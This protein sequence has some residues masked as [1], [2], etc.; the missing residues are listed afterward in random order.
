MEAIKDNA[1]AIYGYGPIPEEVWVYA[2]SFHPTLWKNPPR[3]AAH[4][5]TQEFLK[6]LVP[7]I[8]ALGVYLDEI[9]AAT[10]LDVVKFNPKLLRELP[11]I[12]YK[13]PD[14]LRCAVS[15]DGRML[16]WGAH[17]VRDNK[18]VVL[19][20]VK[21]EGY[22]LKYASHGLKSDREVCLAAVRNE[23]YFPEEPMRWGSF[24]VH[25]QVL[26]LCSL[27][28]QEDKQVV[29]AFLAQ[30]AH[31]MYDDFVFELDSRCNLSAYV[32]QL[33]E[34][35]DNF[36]LFNLGQNEV[37]ERWSAARRATGNLRLPCEN[38]FGQGAA[39]AARFNERILEFLLPCRQ[40]FDEAMA[41]RDK[42]N[43]VRVNRLEKAAL[44]ARADQHRFWEKEKARLY[45]KR[46]RLE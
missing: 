35:Y 37:K 42:L 24:S 33:D 31:T 13:N 7:T 8:P 6:T 34:D 15:Q 45:G 1:R 32:K 14:L 17:S 2:L 36:V 44:E 25:N 10:A 20:A 21:S 46:A 4:L 23:N 40:M 11:D 22:A 27:P 28:L 29:C 5:Y 41:V 38:I 39:C 3:L 26:S 12:H 30:H 16:R 9:D 19:V 43:H 18:E